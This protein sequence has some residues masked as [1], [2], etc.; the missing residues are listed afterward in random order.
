[1]KMFSSPDHPIS[2]CVCPERGSPCCWAAGTAPFSLF[3]RIRHFLFEFA[4]K[5]NKGLEIITI[6]VEFP[7]W[8]CNLFQTLS[9]LLKR[10]W[11]TISSSILRKNLSFG[12][13]IG[14]I[15]NYSKDP[16]FI[17]WN[18]RRSWLKSYTAFRV[19]DRGILP[20]LERW[21]SILSD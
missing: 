18:R 3:I 8:I 4:L 1:M 17:I 6:F 12:L 16:I 21:L 10:I 13:S 5:S 7:A 20:G 15:V 14:I 2:K 19:K 11:S 9:A